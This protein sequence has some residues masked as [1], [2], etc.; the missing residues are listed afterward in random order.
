MKRLL[1]MLCALWAFCSHAED[2][3][4][5]VVFD[6]VP[7]SEFCKVIY[8]QV[9]KEPFVMSSDVTQSNETFTLQ[10]RAVSR[11]QLIDT[12]ESMISSSGFRA[13]RR[14]GVTWIEKAPAA[15]D[16]ILIYRPRYRSSRFLVDV[17][18]SL[19]GARSLQARAIRETGDSPKIE[20]PR[21]EQPTQKKDAPRRSESTTSALAQIDR[22]ETDEIALTVPAAD[23]PKVK[24][25]LAELDAPVPEVMVKAHVYEVTLDDVDKS[26]FSVFADL[27][28]G[29]F[30]LSAGTIASGNYSAVVKAFGLDAVLDVLQS[31][32]RF[33]SVSSS[34]LRV[35]SGAA[36]RL[37]V[38][39]ET[40]VL[41]QSSVD[42]SGNAVQSVE[43]KP[44]GVILDLRPSVHT[45]VIDLQ[46]NQQISNFIS[47]SS[48]VT[49]SPTLI[50]REF[51]TSVGVRDD[52]V[53]ILGG[54]NQDADTRQHDGVRGIPFIGGNS[55]SRK[56]SEIL[57]LLE[58][59]RI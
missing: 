43:Y 14:A 41:G 21:P 9:L 16:E 42:R 15:T 58:A 50:K 28:G 56:K 53:L 47:T 12:A 7:L 44:S 34:Q 52:D 55:S 49:S 25:L 45:D 51:S 46:L 1:L 37:Q 11:R 31:D 48:G 35:Q 22:S 26:A 5:S 29:R 32:T 30:K 20:T 3:S 2:N 10:L 19:T 57:M 13:S 36:A 6:S 27:L 39:A 54:L 23:L 59:R 33:R 17:V 18:Q 38:G 4:V 24:K 8:A 40:P